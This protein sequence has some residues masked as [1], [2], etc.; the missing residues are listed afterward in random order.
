MKRFKKFIKNVDKKYAAVVILLG[1]VLIVLGV[2]I[3]MKAAGCGKNAYVPSFTYADVEEKEDEVYITGL[4]EKGKFDDNIVIPA[5]IEGKKVVS[6]GR[7]AFR[8]AKNL[9]SVTMEE[10]I[11]HI[12]ENAFLGCDNLESVSI[13]ASV[14][15]VGTNAFTNTKWESAMLANSDYIVVNGILIKV[16]QGKAS[17]TVPEGVTVIGSGVFYNN[18]SVTLVEL[19]QSVK[20]IGDYA[21]AGCTALES[22]SLPAETKE[23]GYAAFSGCENLVTE[24]PDSVEKIGVDAFLGVKEVK[25]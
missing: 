25:R 17:Y 9:K 23:I 18:V 21:F 8:D 22:I 7:E 6:I 2:L 11:T 20:V 15:S 5:T 4:T 13:P 14:A 3:A 24:V 19:P 12:S 1:I 16:K 10:G